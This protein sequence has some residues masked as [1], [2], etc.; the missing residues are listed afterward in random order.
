MKRLSSLLFEPISAA[1]YAV[2]RLVVGLLALW[3]LVASWGSR[4]ELYSDQGYFSTKVF[5][6]LLDPSSFTLFR[7]FPSTGA[8]DTI[9]LLAM[10]FS[11]SFAVGFFTRTSGVFLYLMWLSIYNR[12]PNSYPGD[13]L[14][15][16]LFLFPLLFTTCGSFFSVDANKSKPENRECSPIPLYLLRIQL[17]VAYF[18]SGFYKALGDFWLDGTATSIAL[19]NPSVRRFPLDAFWLHPT[20][21]W[22]LKV[23]TWA[24]LIWELSFFLLVSFKKTRP[25]ALGFGITMHTV[26]FLTIETGYFALIMMSAYVVFLDP[27]RVERFLKRGPKDK[28]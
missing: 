5:P 1:P 14:T 18:F 8:V 28:L 25:L 15:V 24:V 3:G 7:W 11:V 4:M 21:W 16:F 10:I 22:T 9:Y 20:I 19:I 12:N 13:E 17:A 2:L 27:D 26:Q 6:G 23:F